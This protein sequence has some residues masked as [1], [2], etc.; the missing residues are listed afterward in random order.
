VSAEWAKRFREILA[1]AESTAQIQERASRLFLLAMRSTEAELLD[2]F[3]E[4]NHSYQLALTNP[5]ERA[6]RRNYAMT[7]ALIITFS[8]NLESSNN[9]PSFFSFDVNPFY[10]GYQLSSPASIAKHGGALIIR[11]ALAFLYS[12]PHW[13]DEAA[14]KLKELV[15]LQTLITF[16]VVVGL[17]VLSLASG[18]GAVASAALTLY[19]LYAIWEDIK[20]LMPLLTDF[21]RAARDAQNDADLGRAGAMLAPLLVGGVVTALEVLLTARAFRLARA[22]VGRVRPPARL[23][24]AHDRAMAELEAKRRSRPKAAAAAEAVLAGVQAEG[25]R[26]LRKDLDSIHPGAVAAGAV[27][28]VGTLGIAAWALSQSKG[29]A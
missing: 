15:T 11:L 6:Q 28:V 22:L 18:L 26:T 27:A 17:W 16:S 1:S 20:A 21:W 9:D 29:D 5:D 2:R 8:P 7:I 4:I 23:R 3:P 10:R 14:D 13:P 25:A 12:I 24:Q 19:G